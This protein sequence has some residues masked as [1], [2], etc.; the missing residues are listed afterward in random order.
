M[1]WTVV[2]VIVV[3]IGLLATLAKPL[4]SL[5]TSI[6]KNTMATDSLSKSME[7]YEADNKAE[8]GE[9][10]NELEEHDGRIS[11]LEGKGE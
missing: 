6:V 5:N 3:L 10:R 2:G 9:I 7:R 4:I 1:E 8:H 11:K